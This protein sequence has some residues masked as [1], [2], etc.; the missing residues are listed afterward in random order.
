MEELALE[1]S[2]PV[3]DGKF[4]TPEVLVEVGGSLGALVGGSQT[5]GI[6]T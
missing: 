4:G 6:F 5:T 2:Q 1:V 3:D